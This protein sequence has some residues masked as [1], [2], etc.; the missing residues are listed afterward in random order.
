MTGLNF[1]TPFAKTYLAFPPQP[2]SNLESKDYLDWTPLSMACIYGRVEIVKLCSIA[3][4]TSKAK[5][6]TGTRR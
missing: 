6:S 3:E 2:P 1:N 5:T 4:R